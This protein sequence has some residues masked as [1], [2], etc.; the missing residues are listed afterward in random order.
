MSSYVVC[1]CLL[2]VAVMVVAASAVLVVEAMMCHTSGQEWGKD[3]QFPQYQAHPWWDRY[4][5][6]DFEQIYF[7]NVCVYGFGSFQQG[8]EGLLGKTDGGNLH[9]KP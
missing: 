9:E 2:W 8:A 1:D 3:A 5:L 6:P 7:R 4:P